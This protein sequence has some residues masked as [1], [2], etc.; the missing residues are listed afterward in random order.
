MRTVLGLIEIGQLDFDVLPIDVQLIRDDHR[1]VSLGT[2]ADFG[3]LG[4]D[5]DGPVRVDADKRI[6]SQRR[7]GLGWGL[8]RERL[9]V[10]AE[11]HS[12]A[13]YRSH[14]KKR[15]AIYNRSFHRGLPLSRRY[16]RRQA[17]SNG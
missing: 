1:Q 8:G 6:R 2:L 9:S 14:F 4:K 7:G 15:P 17:A 12:A 5:V 13:R 16:H 3:V 11:Q 10:Q